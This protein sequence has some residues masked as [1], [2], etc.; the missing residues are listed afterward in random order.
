MTNVDNVID[1]DGGDILKLSVTN[2][3]TGE[4]SDK[5]IH[6]L[7]EAKDFWM[8]LKAASLVFKKAEE[9]LKNWVDYNLGKEEEYRFADGKVL[10]RVYRSTKTWTFDGLRQAGLDEDAISLCSKVDMT[11]AKQ[12]VKEMVEKGEIAPNAGK[13][14]EDS[15]DIKAQ[16]PF[17]EIR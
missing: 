17:V 13:I 1:E 5:E 3:L 10:R 6:S 7:N 9:R 15:A 16:K 8:E 14:L 12:V 4:I 2:L 11:I